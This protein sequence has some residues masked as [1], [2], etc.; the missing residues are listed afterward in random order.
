MRTS[1]LIVEKLE[2]W[3]AWPGWAYFTGWSSHQSHGLVRCLR[4]PTIAVSP[5]WHRA[6]TPTGFVAR[7]R[8]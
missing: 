2:R 7:S 1:E 6:G 8:P 5:R 4:V 3:L